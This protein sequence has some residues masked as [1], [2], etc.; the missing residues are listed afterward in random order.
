MFL[1]K[2]YNYSEMQLIVPNESYFLHILT[3]IGAGHHVVI[4]SKGNS[5]LL[6]RPSTDEIN[7]ALR[8][9]SMQVDIV[10]A[11]T[12]ESNYVI[13]RMKIEDE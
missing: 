11:K 6:I 12:K 2:S 3:E 13:H 9:N 1:A 7:S 4:P 10:L 8:H 5:M